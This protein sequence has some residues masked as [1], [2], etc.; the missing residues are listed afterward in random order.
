MGSP[1]LVPQCRSLVGLDLHSAFI[2]FCLDHSLQYLLYTYLE[3]Y[4]YVTA[5]NDVHSA[6]IETVSVK[7]RLW[8][9]SPQTDTQKLPPPDQSQPVWQSRTV[10]P[11][12]FDQCPGAVTWQ[13]G[14]SEQSAVGG[15]QSAGSGFHHVCSWWN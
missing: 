12:Q 10:V 6:W 15:T 13:P 7:E 11:G 1:L 14:I 5:V 4:R 8:V 2:A 9:P 3:H